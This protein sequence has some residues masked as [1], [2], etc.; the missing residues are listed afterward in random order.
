[1]ASRPGTGLCRAHAADGMHDVDA[2]MTMLA[3]PKPMTGWLSAA[4][5]EVPRSK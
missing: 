3:S 1:M 2:V 5:R 4:V